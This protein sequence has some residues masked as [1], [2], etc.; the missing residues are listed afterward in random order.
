MR[1]LYTT[2]VVAGAALSM[3]VAIAQEAPA[4]QTSHGMVAIG[5]GAIPEYDGSDEI[6]A[7]PFALADVQLGGL[8]LQLRGQGLRIDLASSQRFS[9]GPVLGARMPRE[10]VDGPIG[11]LPELDLAVEAGAFVGYRF[12]GDQFGQGSWHTELSVVQDVSD[13]HDGLLATASVSYALIRQRDI[14]LSLETQATWADQDYTRTYFGV[15]ETDAIA[16]GFN[17]YRPDAGLRDLGMGVTA[18]YWFSPRLGVIGR[19]GTTYLLGDAAD[20]PIIEE[21][22]SR[23]QPVAGLALSY[24]Y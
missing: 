14:F 11:R 18:G 17:A 19:V 24:R 16:S 12:G 20:S 1:I 8:N 22:G 4:E 2:T 5:I 7:L 9:A 3:S 10:D 23:W 15:E 6:R 13:V 21:E